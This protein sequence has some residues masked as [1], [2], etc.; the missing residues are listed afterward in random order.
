MARSERRKPRRSGASSA[1]SSL[2]LLFAEVLMTAAAS[3]AGR[4]DLRLDGC[5]VAALAD[6]DELRDFVLEV[7][8][9]LL[10]LVGIL[11]DRGQGCGLDA[12]LVLGALGEAV[13]G[14][15]VEHREKLGISHDDVLAVRRLPLCD[16][17]ERAEVLALQRHCRLALLDQHLGFRL[18]ERG[19]DIAD[20]DGKRNARQPDVLGHHSSLLE[21]NSGSQLGTPPDRT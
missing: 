11:P 4:A 13:P 3:L 19:G 6:L 7:L 8:L 20:A 1:R 10:E 15:L 17:G 12:L 5:F 16:R 14:H 9:G 18:R 21:W 2:L